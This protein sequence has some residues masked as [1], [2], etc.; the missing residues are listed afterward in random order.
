MTKPTTL[1][2][3]TQHRTDHDKAWKNPTPIVNGILGKAHPRGHA[4]FIDDPDVEGIV[5]HPW[6]DYKENL[7]SPIV[8]AKSITPLKFQAIMNG[9]ERVW[10]F[11]DMFLR[12]RQWC[13]V[14][15]AILLLGVLEVDEE[16]L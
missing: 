1:P 11:D 6:H 10:L 12:V 15:N 13:L 3:L 4:T 8:L 16:E 9:N 5:I 7:S 2:P 14:E